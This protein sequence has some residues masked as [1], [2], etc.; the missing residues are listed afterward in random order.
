M[1]APRTFAELVEAVGS[2]AAPV[3][4]LTAAMVEYAGLDDEQAF[5]GA[6]AAL[7]RHATTQVSYQSARRLVLDA[8]DLATP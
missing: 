2:D 6:R 7:D 1:T 3:A 5:R 8:I 4:I